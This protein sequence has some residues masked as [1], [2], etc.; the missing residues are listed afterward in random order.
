MAITTKSREVNI[1]MKH[2]I[3]A[4]AN[5]AAAVTALVYLVC[6]IGVW[7]APDLSMT[8]AQSWFHNIDITT[9]P[10]PTSDSGTFIFGLVTATVAAWLAGYAFAWT[11]NWFLKKK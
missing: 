6:R 10:P 1:T 9:L 3:N 8:I 5:A 7:L 4:T 11:Y 2:D